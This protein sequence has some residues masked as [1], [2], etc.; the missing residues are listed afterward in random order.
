MAAPLLL[1]GLPHAGAHDLANAL[2]LCGVTL[3]ATTAPELGRWLGRVLAA[4]WTT[5]TPDDSALRARFMQEAQALAAH[6]DDGLPWAWIELDAAR[7]LPYW[8]AA[9]PALRVIV[10]VREPDAHLAAL[11]QHDRRL[12]LD[13]AAARWHDLYDAL[14]DDASVVAIVDYDALLRDPAAVLRRVLAQ[15]DIAVRDD[16]ITAAAAT[17]VARG[18]VPAIPL[19]AVHTTYT[20][21]AA[22]AGLT[23][24][25]PDETAAPAT[26]R[27]ELSWPATFTPE[28]TE[29]DRL[30]E[31]MMYGL[32][33]RM[34]RRI[35]TLLRDVVNKGQRK[36][37]PALPALT[38]VTVIGDGQDGAFEQTCKSVLA[39]SAAGWRWLVM[40]AAPPE[41]LTALAQREPHI[42]LIAPP[43]GAMNTA[44]LWNA[45]LEQA[46]TA[47]VMPLF[48]GDQLSPT[49]LAQVAHALHSQPDADCI[50][51]DAA[52]QSPGARD[53]LPFYKPDWSPAMMFSVNLLDGLLVLRRTLLERAGLL[54]TALGDAAYWDFCWRAAHHAGQI[55]HIPA[56]LCH[57]VRPLEPAAV[58]RAA[59]QQAAL[60][61]AGITPHSV[62]PPRWEA[63]LPRVSIIIPSR[64]KSALLGT[65]LRTLFTLT[66]YPDFDV[67]VVDT[68]SVETATFALYDSYGDE[69]RF[70]VVRYLDEPFNFSRAC[71]IGAAQA[72]GELL[73]FLNND[74]EVIQAE[75]L[76]R[77]VQW[78]A[79]PS[80]GMVGPKLLYPDGTVQHAGVIIGLSGLANHIWQG[81]MENTLTVFGSDGWYRNFSAVTAACALIRRDVF[82]AIGGFSERYQLNFSDVELCLQ[83]VRRGYQIIYTPDARLTHHEGQSHGYRIP[84]QDFEQASRDFRDWLIR[85]DPFFNPNL[86][87]TDV[88]PREKHGRLISPYAVHVMA[89][90][91]QRRLAGHTRDEP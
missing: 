36:T 3:D 79:D 15:V 9:F 65:C 24:P 77:M 29:I 62:N 25:A 71:N 32:V 5:A 46:E 52:Y 33:R 76:S 27:A 38:L 61:R 55:H 47:F 84:H 60:T 82:M 12:T 66:D 51:G 43:A 26:P 40:C 42:Q 64:D 68:N 1:A 6:Y 21:L 67:T 11:L 63:A 2:A 80:V 57:C 13:Q 86:S 17:I 48:A 56:V 28:L 53:E 73:L 7:T 49:A 22:R 8:R 41:A 69:P 37:L 78:F 10:C 72:S 20:A 74:T 45:A 81:G 58:V 34:K 18:T 14:R 4:R 44:T 70:R 59:A 16:D 75:W 35:R 19:P 85:G 30:I 89:M 91:R 88:Q 23:L 83:V 31:G 90:A 54:D 87:Y 50:Y 39:Q